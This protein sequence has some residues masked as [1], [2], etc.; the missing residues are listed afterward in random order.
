L[1][2]GLTKNYRYPGWRVGWA[3]GPEP[4]IESMARTSSSIDG[5]PSRV[6]QRIALDALEPS[7]ADQ[8]TTALRD[9]FAEKRATMLES[10]RE[11]G[12]RFDFDPLGT[13]YCWG[14]LADLPEPFNDAMTFFWRALDHRVMTV[15]GQFF[16]VNPGAYRQ[17]AY[18]RGRSPYE[19]WMRFSFGPPADNME[20]G[21]ERLHEMIRGG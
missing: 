21:L 20:A 6:A 4:M 17:A 10:L 13:F 2:D 15:P 8:E 12:V 18:R 14:S 1:I 9:V 7:Q 3:V 16:D 5:G 11:L 19:S